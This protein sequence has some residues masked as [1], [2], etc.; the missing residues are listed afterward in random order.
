MLIYDAY[1]ETYIDLIVIVLLVVEK[2]KLILE[3]VVQVLNLNSFKVG[4][5]SLCALTHYLF[6]ST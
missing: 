4:S 3:S 5:K 1:R 6:I 2:V